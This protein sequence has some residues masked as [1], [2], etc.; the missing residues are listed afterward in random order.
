MAHVTTEE[1]AKALSRFYDAVREP[2][3]RSDARDEGPVQRGVATLRPSRPSQIEDTRH[4]GSAV[5]VGLKV[6]SV[7]QDIQPSL[8]RRPLAPVA[9]QVRNEACSTEQRLASGEHGL[10]RHIID[11][12]EHVGVENVG[13]AVVA[14]KG[15]PSVLHNAAFKRSNLLGV[16]KG[17]E[18][19]PRDAVHVIQVAFPDAVHVLRLHPVSRRTPKKGSKR[20]H[21]ASAIVPRY[22]GIVFG[23][24]RAHDV[25]IEGERPSDAGWVARTAVLGRCLRGAVPSRAAAC[26]EL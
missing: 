24:W 13:R 17:R 6:V 2:A 3:L 9:V 23:S 15:G 25:Q 21:H 26:G 4:E 11:T 8:H 19:G 14:T 1:E 20:L 10:A 16:G 5:V 18:P 12:L 7:A 22:W